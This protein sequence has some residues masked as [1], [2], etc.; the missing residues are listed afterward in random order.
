MREALS[1]IVQHASATKANVSMN[2]DLDGEVTVVI[3]DNGVGMPGINQLE[4]HYGLPIMRERAQGLN[5]IL[6]IG[7]S[8]LGG[9]AV[10]LN[11][12][13]SPSSLG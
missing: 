11:F 4:H 5:G 2:C 13:A 1:N 6:H 7:P 12:H 8:S 3:E 9:T 10:K